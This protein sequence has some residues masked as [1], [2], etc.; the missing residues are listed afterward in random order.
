MGQRDRKNNFRMTGCMVLILTAALMLTGCT[1]V[2]QGRL[3][4][5]IKSKYA[6]QGFTIKGEV[7]GQFG[8]AVVMSPD[9]NPDLVFRVEMDE[10]NNLVDNYAE[11]VASIQA[12]EDA[13]NAAGDS[14]CCYIWCELIK[15]D[16]AEITPG[17]S[18]EEIF[19]SSPETFM[20]MVIVLDGNSYGPEEA[21][22]LMER[23]AEAL[24]Y[25]KGK[26][27][28]VLRDQETMFEIKGYLSTHEAIYKDG[29]EI[30]KSNT[31][32]A[33]YNEGSIQGTYEDFIMTFN[34]S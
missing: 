12:A 8:K 19:S 32:S 3:R 18:A 28:T 34:V 24:P 16:D 9:E 31:G 27:F 2:R 25:S 15:G 5:A 14:V 33:S 1:S 7:K 22:A 26:M 11:R 17:T 4:S 29:L 10:D 23:V 20:N 21:Y 6:R 13:L 30:I